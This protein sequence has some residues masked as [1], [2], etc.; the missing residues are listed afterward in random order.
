M[1]LDG[2]SDPDSSLYRIWSRPACAL[3]GTAAVLGTS[4]A[5][6]VLMAGYRLRRPVTLPGH[7]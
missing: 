3:G 5:V 2:E 1:F 4:P 7:G 6:R